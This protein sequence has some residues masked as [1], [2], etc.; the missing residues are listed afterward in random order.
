MAK[1]HQ[2]GAASGK[3]TVTM[4]RWYFTEK[5]KKKS[6]VL[7]DISE[8]LDDEFR[9]VLSD[10]Q[11]RVGNAAFFAEVVQAPPRGELI[12]HD[13]TLKYMMGEFNLPAG[14]RD[15]LVRVLGDVVQC[16]KG[17]VEYT[18]QNRLDERY[19]AY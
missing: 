3:V 14:S 6:R 5:P 2:K 17:G 18:G 4:P 16:A 11:K 1:T 9:F 12:G 15:V 8:P 13:G 7:L 10:A 19:P